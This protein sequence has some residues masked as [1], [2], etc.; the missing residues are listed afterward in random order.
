MANVF[1]TFEA[2][3]NLVSDSYKISAEGK[4]EI[5]RSQTIETEIRKIQIETDTKRLAL[6]LQ[7]PD[8]IEDEMKILQKDFEEIA[9]PT[10]NDVILQNSGK[11]LLLASKDLLIVLDTIKGTANIGDILVKMGKN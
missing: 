5:E 10:S 8:Y 9:I 11:L 4:K 3:I 1:S 7:S 6:V 2:L